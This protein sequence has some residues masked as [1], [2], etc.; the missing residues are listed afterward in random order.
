MKR[1]NVMLIPIVES[2]HTRK[3]AGF[4]KDRDQALKI[5]AEDCNPKFTNVEEVMTHKVVTRHIDDYLQKVMDAV[6]EN[7]YAVSWL[8][9]PTEG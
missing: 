8:L 5:V 1:L 6:A 2:E 7:R 9:T 3:L 4:V